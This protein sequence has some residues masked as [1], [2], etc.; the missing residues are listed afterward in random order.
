LIVPCEVAVRSVVPAVKALVAI[1]MVEKRGLKQDE[2]AKILGIS[3]SAVS[4]YTSKTRGYVITVDNTDDVQPLINKMI[5][6]LL[7][8]D[9]QRQDLLASFCQTCATIRKKS[10]MCKL[11]QKTDPQIKIEECNFC[12]LYDSPRS[13]R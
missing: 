9:Y 2:V 10:L 3:Q 8:G 7:R 6:L 1:E 11:C 12:L 4:K 13:K 5:A